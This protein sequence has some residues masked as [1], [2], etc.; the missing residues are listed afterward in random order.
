MAPVW[1]IRALD[2]NMDGREDLWMTQNTSGLRPEFARIDAGRGVLLTLNKNGRGWEILSSSATGLALPEEARGSVVGDWNQ[3]L[4]PDL[5][6]STKAGRPILFENQ[7]SKQGIQVTLKGPPGNP[8]GI[9]AMIRLR[10]KSGMGP[11]REIRSGGGSGALDTMSP[12]L[13]NDENLE[14]VWVRWPGGRVGLTKIDSLNNQRI[15]LN[16]LEEP[17]P[18]KQVN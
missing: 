14:Y 10:T 1:D 17:S 15:E 3:D 18:D 16:W 7:M 12:I 5:V 13:G 8:H 9:G 6:V 2:A 11:A 4:R